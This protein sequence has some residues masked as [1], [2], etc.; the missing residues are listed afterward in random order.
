MTLIKQYGDATLTRRYLHLKSQHCAKNDT[1]DRAS[2][3]TFETVLSF[4]LLNC[5]YS[6]KCDLKL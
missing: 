4:T 3:V 5:H 1:T 6:Q 2:V